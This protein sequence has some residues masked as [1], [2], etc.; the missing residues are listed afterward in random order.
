MAATPHAE[1][2]AAALGTARRWRSG[3]IR[4]NELLTSATAVV[5]IALL[6]AEG[7]TIL[8]LRDLVDEHMFIGLV[9]IPP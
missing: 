6:A 9:L 5:L 3:G 8:D 7:V 2:P 1:A 4:G